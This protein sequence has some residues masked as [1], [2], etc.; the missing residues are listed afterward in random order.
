MKIC[1]EDDKIIITLEKTLDTT[2]ATNAEEMIMSE[3]DKSVTNSAVF[4]AKILNIFQVLVCEC[5]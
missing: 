2:N 4:D 5:F 3:I 1:R